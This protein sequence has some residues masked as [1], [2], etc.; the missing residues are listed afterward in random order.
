MLGVLSASAQYIPVEPNPYGERAVIVPVPASVTGIGSP[1]LNLNEG[2]FIGEYPEEDFYAET[3]LP[4][5]FK[6]YTIDGTGWVNRETR[7]IAGFWRKI[8]VPQEFSG[9][10]VILRFNSTAHDATLWVNGKFVR[11]HWGSYGSWTADITDFVQAGSEAVLAVRLDQRPVGLVPFV[12]FSANFQ[13]D[14]QLYAVPQNY[15]QRLRIHTDLDAAYKDA[16]LQLWLKFPEAASGTLK[17]NLVDAKG[18]KLATS[19]SSIKLPAGMDEFKYDFTV[20]NPKKW[21]SEHPNLYKLTLTLTDASDKQQT[22]KV[23]D[24]K[25]TKGKHDV[26]IKFMAREQGQKDNLF[27][28]DWWQAK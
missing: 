12:R 21:D 3:A 17:L 10:R 15:I 16:T 28:F 4:S 26:Y 5:G 22:M 19:P 9:K 7:N 2:W 24:K 13:G 6:P 27:D 11:K 1:L 8:M 18:K 25:A 20:K 23:L 14:V